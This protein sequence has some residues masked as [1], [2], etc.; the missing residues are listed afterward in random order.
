[1]VGFSAFL[2]A[3]SLRSST[4]KLKLERL[5]LNH[6]RPVPETGGEEG[7]YL[8]VERGN[9]SHG[10]RQETLNRWASKRCFWFRQRFPHNTQGEFLLFFSFSIDCRLE[11]A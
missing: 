7:R 4:L 2:T 8:R 11:S 10:S 5:N 6:G 1:M 3:F 9:R